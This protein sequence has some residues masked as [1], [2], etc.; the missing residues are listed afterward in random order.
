LK[1][2]KKKLIRK[3]KV[4]PTDRTYFFGDVSGNK[5]HFFTPKEL[6]KSQ[7]NPRAVLHFKILILKKK[8]DRH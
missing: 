3:I 8:T 2:K 7:K 1:K 4:M 6:K 5:E